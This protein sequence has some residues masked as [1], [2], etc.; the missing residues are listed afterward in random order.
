MAAFSEARRVA[1]PRCALYTY[2]ASTAT[3]LALLLAGW[4]VGVGDPIGDKA[5][6]TAAAV[7]VDDLARPLDRGWLARL[8]RPGRSAAAR[9]APDAI[10]RARLAPQFGL[11]RS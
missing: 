10:A 9:R 1:S 3:R 7:A 8:S 6:T 5:Q 4:A 2:S 11:P